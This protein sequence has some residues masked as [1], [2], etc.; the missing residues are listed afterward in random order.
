MRH[1]NIVA[2]IGAARSRL[3]LFSEW[4]PNGT[5]AE[6]LRENHGANRIDLASLSCSIAGGLITLFSAV[7]R[8]RR[9]HLPSRKPHNTRRL[10]GGWCLFQI[11]L[12][13]IGDLRLVQHSHR[14]WRPRS[15][16]RLW[17]Y[18]GG[19]RERLRPCDPG[20][21]LHR[22]VGCARGSQEWG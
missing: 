16:D 19:S 10:E 14:Q 22:K 11:V 12:N 3:L 13:C 15:F 2:F 7:G 8:G 21:G 5:I 9:P 20:T 18:F 17:F 1:P 6:Y 4:M